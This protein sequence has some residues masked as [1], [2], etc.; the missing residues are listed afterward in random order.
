MGAC[1]ARS[2]AQ[3]DLSENYKYFLQIDSHTQFTKN[4]DK[5]IILNY[6][7]SK[8]RW[9]NMIYTTYVFAYFYENEK[10]KYGEY[11]LPT[12]VCLHKTLHP[13]FFEGRYTHYDGDSLG[14]E[15]NYFS[16]HFAFGDSL[17][18]LNTPYD[19]ELYFSCE[20]PSIAARLHNKDIKLIVPPLNFIYHN[21]RYTL[22]LSP[23]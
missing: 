15:T 21:C 5:E 7:M 12:A 17:I 1:W 18:F 22:I 19:K 3:E 4:W 10:I 9:P 16:G 14:F 2:L 6:N 13:P 11:N 20:E 8:T 23:S